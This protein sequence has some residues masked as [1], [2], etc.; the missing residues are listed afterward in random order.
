MLIKLELNLCNI[1]SNNLKTIYINIIND[2]LL[3]NYNLKM[4]FPPREQPHRFRCRFDG[5][6]RT[7]R[8]DIYD[9]FLILSH[10]LKSLSFHHLHNSISPGGLIMTF[11]VERTACAT[12]TE[13]L[14]SDKLLYNLFSIETNTRNLRMF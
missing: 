13:T 14:L 3:I 7:E 2:L 6:D 12:K 1:F 5:T 8:I 11:L 9:I 4:Y 10:W